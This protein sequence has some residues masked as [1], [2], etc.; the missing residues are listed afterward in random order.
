[1]IEA[2]ENGLARCGV[3]WGYGSQEELKN[4]GAQTVVETPSEL[5]PAIGRGALCARPSD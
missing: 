5:I 3:L 4:S 2:R 1:M